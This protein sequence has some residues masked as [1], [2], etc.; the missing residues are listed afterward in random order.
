[1]RKI[2]FLLLTCCCLN[3][4]LPFS[5]SA[6]PV[7]SSCSEYYID[8]E[9]RT[10]DIINQIRA[11]HNLAPLTVWNQLCEISRG[12]C[13]NMAEKKCSFGHDGFD[14]RSKGVDSDKFVYRFGENVAFNFNYKDPVKVAVEGWM[15]SPGHRKNILGDYNETGV[16]IVQNTRGEWYLTQLF[17]KRAAE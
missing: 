9:T 1:M 6:A 16:G 15:E 11:K 3:L 8:M 7:R 14:K 17:A 10:V 12:H 5:A 4:T 2:L 13:L